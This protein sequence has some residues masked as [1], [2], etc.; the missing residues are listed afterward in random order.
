MPS[1]KPEEAQELVFELFLD[2]GATD[3]QLD[4]T[5]IYTIARDGIAKINL[6]DDSKDLTPLLDTILKVVPVASS[7]EAINKPLRVQPFNLAYDNFLGRLAIGRIYEGK[8]TQGSDVVV[9][10]VK[11]EMRSRTVTK[12]FTFEG[13]N[14]KEVDVACAGDIV[15][16]AGLPNIF[17]GE[18]ICE[19][20]NQEALPAI[21]IDEPTISLNFLVN[22]S[23][24][25][26]L[27][28]K[29]VTNRQLKERLDKELEVNVGLK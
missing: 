9:K 17:I 22:N 14:R 25:A 2:L 19:D 10:K 27:D 13:L 5:T 15:M 23:P 20:E 29:F 3:E 26:G 4:F 24:F 6:D 21:N 7:P 12:L 16:I 28:G 18:T 8:I 1:A 11:G